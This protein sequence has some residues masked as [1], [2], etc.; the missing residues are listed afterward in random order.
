MITVVATD[1]LVSLEVF[2]AG[3]G[4]GQSLSKLSLFSYGA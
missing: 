2:I 1:G 4:L 3:V